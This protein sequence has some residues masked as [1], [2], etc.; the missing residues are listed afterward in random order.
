MN[1]FKKKGLIFEDVVTVKITNI[2]YHNQRFFFF[3]K[4]E[5]G[6][7]GLIGFP[8]MTGAPGPIGLPGM[9]S[10]SA[11]ETSCFYH[12][13]AIAEPECNSLLLQLFVFWRFGYLNF[14]VSFPELDISYF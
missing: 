8:G 11:D 3:F 4:G 14:Y 10:F 6:V 12:V 5:R 13:F 2:F 7:T 9:V 1:F